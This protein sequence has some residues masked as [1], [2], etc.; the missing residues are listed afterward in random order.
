MCKVNLPFEPSVST[1][2]VTEGCNVVVSQFE[3]EPAA[4][5]HPGGILVTHKVI[6]TL[7]ALLLQPAVGISVC[8]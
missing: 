8:H 4:E 6:I 5:M 1:D 3:S 2:D 7:V